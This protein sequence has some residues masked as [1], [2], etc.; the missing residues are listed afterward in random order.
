M[1]MIGQVSLSIQP[2]TLVVEKLCH[3]MIIS[4]RD[5]IRLEVI[6]N[7]FLILLEPGNVND[8]QNEAD[9]IK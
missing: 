4:W 8:I 5:C 9:A 2:N 1:K 3:K 6:P 7:N